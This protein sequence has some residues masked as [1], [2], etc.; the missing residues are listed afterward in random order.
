MAFDP[1]LLQGAVDPEPIETRLLDDD[2]PIA[3]ARPRLR[4]RLQR[5]KQIQ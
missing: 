1:F 5:G 3:V 2:D 4:L